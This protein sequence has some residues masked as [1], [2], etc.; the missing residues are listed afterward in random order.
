MLLYFN[1]RFVS[2][3]YNI[4]YTDTTSNLHPFGNWT[5]STGGYAVDGPDYSS[6]SN[7]SING[8][9]WIVLEISSSKRNGNNIDL[10][11]FYMKL[12]YIVIK[13]LVLI[14][15]HIFIKMVYLVH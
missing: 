12:L 6:Y 15:K 5:N 7:T 13:I 3:G 11:T 2:G 9:K 14:T 1:D 10:S 4:N 8:F